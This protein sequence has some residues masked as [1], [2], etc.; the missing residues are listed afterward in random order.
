MCGVRSGAGTAEGSGRAAAAA[1]AGTGAARAR[2]GDMAGG[3]GAWPQGPPDG[4]AGGSGE[5]TKLVGLPRAWRPESGV[6]MRGSRVGLGPRGGGAGRVSPGRS[7]FAV[8]GLGQGQGAAL[9]RSR[10]DPGDRDARHRHP[11]LQLPVCAPRGCLRLD[12]LRRR[13]QARGSR[14]APH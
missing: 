13:P 6:R 3:K 7:Y 4:G 9:D 1:A 14:F 8:P 2:G 12:P 11:P 10:R 5:L